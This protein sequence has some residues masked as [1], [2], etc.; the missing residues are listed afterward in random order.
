MDATD[1]NGKKETYYGYIEEIW[2]L[3]YEPILKIPLFRCRWVKLAGGG[4]TKGQY[5]ITIVDLN[6]LEYRDKP[7]ILA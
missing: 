5:G 4:V 2:E 1:N 7:F 6:N 3:D